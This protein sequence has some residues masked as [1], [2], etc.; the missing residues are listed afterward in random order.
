ME[1]EEMMY[2]YRYGIIIKVCL[3]IDFKV[4][5]GELFWEKGVFLKMSLE[6][7]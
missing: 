7:E 6:N 1:K 3:G 5:S 4:K 2:K